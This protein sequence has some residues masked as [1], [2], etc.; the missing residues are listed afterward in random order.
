MLA[1][2][3]AQ[4]ENTIL[5]RADIQ[6]VNTQKFTEWKNFIEQNGYRPR[7]IIVGEERALLSVEAYE[8]E[9]R[10][11]R[12]GD[13]VS[14]QI[15]GHVPYAIDW[16]DPERQE[17]EFIEWWNRAPTWQQKNNTD[18]LNGC[19]EFSARKGCRPRQ[20]ISAEEAKQMSPEELENELKRGVWMAHTV[21][22]LN[23]GEKSPRDWQYPERQQAEFVEWYAKTPTYYQKQNAD[24]FTA[25]KAFIVQHGYRPRQSIS[26]EVR[27]QMTKAEYEQEVELG[28]WANSIS[29][30]LPEWNTD[31]WQYEEQHNE[32]KEL[33]Q[34]IP[35]FNQKLNADRLLLL[36]KFCQ[37]NGYRPSHD[38]S[39]IHPDIVSAGEISPEENALAIFVD[40]V[41]AGNCA[42]QYPEQYR[43]F[44]ECLKYPT[45]LMF[46][47]REN[48]RRSRRRLA[49][50]S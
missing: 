50:A 1:K 38:T 35:T 18:N 29:Q 21:Q 13:H 10:L 33:W 31:V 44:E 39:K 24:R 26:A 28:K 3:V 5:T 8:L 12:W 30:F 9:T 11:G 23:A 25:W 19:Q 43:E 45:H 49:T 22:T 46:L 36:K 40:S 15:K 4:I 47:Q 32:F 42:F 7:A 41:R 16:E 48:S 37:D 27:K 6:R 17:A 2:N 34:K 14:Q 20:E